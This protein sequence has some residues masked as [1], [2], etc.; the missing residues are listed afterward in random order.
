M[1]L[2]YLRLSSFG[3]MLG[4]TSTSCTY[5]FNSIEATLGMLNKARLSELEPNIRNLS[6]P[7]MDF[8]AGTKKHPLSSVAFLF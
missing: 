3:R 4:I 1:G 7:C 2:H 8:T 5:V 6:S